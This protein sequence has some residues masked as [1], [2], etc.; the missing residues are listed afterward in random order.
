LLADTHER[1]LVA[2]IRVV[3]AD[4]HHAVVAKVRGVLGADF[5]VVDAVSDGSQAVDAVLRLDPEVL[6]IDISMP[7]LDGLQAASRLQQA[8]CRAKIIMLTIHEDQDYVD[9]A[10]RA[11]ASGYVTKSRLSTDLIPAIRAAL[12]GRTFVSQTVSN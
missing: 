4:D 7:V 11:G 10:L 2:K 8:K 6:V 1:V 12:Q 9:A 3:L 5:E